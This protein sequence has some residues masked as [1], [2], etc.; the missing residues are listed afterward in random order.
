MLLDYPAHKYT[1][2]KPKSFWLCVFFSSMLVAAYLSLQNILNPVHFAKITISTANFIALCSFFLSNFQIYR[3][4]NE[5]PDAFSFLQKC[6]IIM[7][8]LWG[9]SNVAELHIEN[10]AVK[11]IIYLVELIGILSL[12]LHVYSDRQKS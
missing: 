3:L 10:S 7:F 4:K 2:R 6:L 11:A 5:Q 1:M 9:I 12:I 8:L